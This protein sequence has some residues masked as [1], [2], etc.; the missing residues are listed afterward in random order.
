MASEWLDVSATTPR[1][2]YTATAAQTVFVVPFVFF[3]DSNLKVYQNGA[4]K[5]LATDYTVLGSEDEDGGTV[6]LLT[7]ATAGDEIMIARLLVIEQTTHIPPSGPLDIQAINI[8]ISRI[9][10]MLQQMENDLDRSLQ[11]PDN[12]SGELEIAQPVAGEFL[13]WNATGDGIESTAIIMPDGS[14]AIATESEAIAGTVNDALMTPLRVAQEVAPM[15]AAAISA[16]GGDAVFQ[17]ADAGSVPLT[18]F[19]I[20]KEWHTLPMYGGGTAKTATENAAAF[21]AARNVLRHGGTLT[22]TP[23]EYDC[24]PVDWTVADGG[25]TVGM[26]IEGT[27]GLNTLANNRINFYGTGATPFW[28]FDAPASGGFGGAA[29]TIRGLYIIAWEPTFSGALISSTTSVTDGSKITSHFWMEQC[30]LSQ[31]GGV[32]GVCTLIDIGKAI[33]VTIHKCQLG[34]GLVQIK[35]Q[36]GLTVAGIAQPRQS[37]TVDIRKTHF[38][39]SNGHPILYGGEA[40]ALHDNMFEPTAGGRGRVFATNANYPILNM[41]WINNWCGDYSGTDTDQAFIFFGH[42]LVFMGN[43]VTGTNAPG[44]WNAIS[45]N[46]FKGFKIEANT[47]NYC[48]AAIVSNGVATNYGSIEANLHNVGSITSGSFGAGVRIEGNGT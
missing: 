41:T 32:S 26:I 40:W 2:A 14:Y 42:G 20:I 3:E 17:Q 1:I 39:G 12:V 7:G 44:G 38:S 4:L 21:V 23:G 46:S 19:E 48:T 35:G 6:T 11:L 45:L 36:Q 16:D 31:Q 9:I 24:D 10:A 8:Q 43:T 33:G 47:L 13:K 34:G 37:T 15:I 18:Y 27:G 25:T 29:M 22:V 30:T 28:N 5:T